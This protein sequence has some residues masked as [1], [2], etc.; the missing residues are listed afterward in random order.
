MHL[1]VETCSPQLFVMDYQGGED[2]SEL[3]MWDVGCVMY[4]RYM[5]RPKDYLTSKDRLRGR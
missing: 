1:E 2:G 3:G 5:Q 4:L